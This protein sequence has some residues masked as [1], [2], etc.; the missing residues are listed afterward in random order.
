MNLLE[1]IK[2]INFINTQ[3]A[4]KLELGP[5]D[6]SESMEGKTTSATIDQLEI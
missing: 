6:S 4:V 2:D 3:F 1:N 5:S